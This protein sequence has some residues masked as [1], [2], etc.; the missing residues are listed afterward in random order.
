VALKKV[1]IVSMTGTMG[2]GIAQVCAQSGYQVIGSSRNI[3]KVNKTIDSIKARLTK[4][5]EKGTLPKADMEATMSRLKGT[6]SFQDFADCDL[7]IEASADDMALKKSIFAELDKV[8][9]KTAI[10]ASNTSVLSIIDLAVATTRPDKV[11]GIHFF[12]PV[13]LMKLVEIVKTIATGDETV[14]ICQEFCKSI[15]KETVLAKDTPGFIVNRLG[16]PFMLDA[17]R[18]LENGTA[19]RDDIDN[20]VRLALN[21]PIG[22]LALLDLIGIDVVYAGC[23]A[24]YDE[25]KDPKF[26]PPVLLKRMVAAGWLGRKTGKGFYDYNK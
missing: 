24:M 26:A 18:L 4:S 5:V 22:P 6:T 8:C 9:P 16:A 21:H 2:I 13:P 17:V 12:N 7:V 19:S 1:G 15:G 25:T 23:S 3:D 14:K 20:A 10:L 11:L